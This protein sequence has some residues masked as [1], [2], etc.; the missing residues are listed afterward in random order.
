MTGEGRVIISYTVVVNEH[1]YNGNGCLYSRSSFSRDV[2][3]CVRARMFIHSSECL[4]LCL[5]DYHSIALGNFLFSFYTITTAPTTT[6]VV[7]AAAI[8]IIIIFTLE[9]LREAPRWLR[10]RLEITS[11]N[12]A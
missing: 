4:F 8:T 5:L 2:C 12:L 6:A 3:A 11:Y 1:H 10:D 9:P 7:V